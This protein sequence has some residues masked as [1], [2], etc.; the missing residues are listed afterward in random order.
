MAARRNKV[1]TNSCLFCTVSPKRERGK[2]FSSLLKVQRYKPTTLCKE[3]KPHF[4][5]AFVFFF[6][7]F[8]FVPH[9]FQ[10]L[11]FFIDGALLFC[12]QTRPSAIKLSFS[13][14]SVAFVGPH[15]FPFSTEGGVLNVLHQTHGISLPLIIHTTPF[16]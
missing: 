4:L 8:Y 11:I 1:S 10:N 13:T 9:H 15:H 12:S 5:F 14:F 2:I 3:K 7:S 16:L 6:P